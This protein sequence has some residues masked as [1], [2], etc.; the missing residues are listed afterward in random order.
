MFTRFC[1]SLA[2][3]ALA[4]PT[5]ALSQW[6]SSGRDAIYTMYL[7]QAKKSET[8][9]I[10]LVSYEKRWAC[11]PIIS[12]MLMVGRKLGTPERQATET[13]RE[14][15]LSI[16]VDGKVFMSETKITKYSNG[17]ELAMLAP[18]GLIDAL[19]NQ[20]SSVVARLGAGLGG[21]DFSHTKGFAAANASATANCS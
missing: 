12:V 5:T 11:Q 15:Q 6:V 20:P 18:I 13:K 1:I 3:I 7:P 19:K 16:V 9:A 2:T 17:M 21:F 14:D 8:H 10:F 4:F